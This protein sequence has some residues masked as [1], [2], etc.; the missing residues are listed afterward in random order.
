MSYLES[1]KDACSIVRLSKSNKAI[2]VYELWLELGSR[3]PS[4]DACRIQASLMQSKWGGK[5]LYRIEAG[6]LQNGAGMELE[7]NLE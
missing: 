2:V 5:A 1:S 4:F 7:W 6:D 3:R